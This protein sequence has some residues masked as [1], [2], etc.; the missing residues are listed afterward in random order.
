MAI[1]TPYQNTPEA[2]E[3]RKPDPIEVGRDTSMVGA[4]LQAGAQVL[5]A[6]LKVTDQI[7]KDRIDQRLF[8]DINLKRQEDTI[9]QAS[10]L[11]PATP[12]TTPDATVDIGTTNDQTLPHQVQEA[13][14][15]MSI[16]AQANKMGR[17]NDIQ[18]YGEMQEINQRIASQY[19]GYARYIQDRSAHWLGTNSANAQR[20][21]IQ[22]TLAQL[23]ATQ[24]GDAEKWSN[25]M[26]RDRKFFLK[27]D[28]T[29]DERAFAGAL[30]ATDP[31]VR[32]GIRVSIARQAAT[33]HSMDL[34]KK[35]MELESTSNT[36]S[37]QRAQQHYTQL[38]ELETARYTERAQFNF[39]GRSMKIKDINEFVARVRA[40]GG[41]VKP[42]VL[43]QLGAVAAQFEEGLDKA[44]QKVELD[45]I[46][47][48]GRNIAGTVKDKASL[49]KIRDF[50][51][52]NVF[53]SIKRNI[54]A[55][56]MA[57]ATSMLNTTAGRQE[58]AGFKLLENEVLGS[59]AGL[60]K[61]VG[62]QAAAAIVNHQ[63]TKMGGLGL[64]AL[65][66]TTKRLRMQQIASSS[67]FGSLNT[68]LEHFNMLNPAPG[69]VLT[70]EQQRER[71]TYLKSEIDTIKD[72]IVQKDAPAQSPELAV[73]AAR[74]ITQAGSTEFIT[75]FDKNQ[76]M[77]VYANI[78]APEVQKKIKELSQ[79]DPQLWK[80]YT[81]WN[82]YTFKRLYNTQIASLQQG[83]QDTAG[84]NLRWG[85][86]GQIT[87]QNP[88]GLQGQANAGVLSP[89]ATT[90]QAINNLNTGLATLRGVA[91]LNGEKLTPEFLKQFGI[92]L[93]LPPNPSMG[94]PNKNK[95]TSEAPNG[96]EGLPRVS[97]S[98]IGS[99]QAAEGRPVRTES[100]GG[101][102]N[103][104]LP[105]QFDSTFDQLI[106][107]GTNEPL[108]E[109]GQRRLQQRR[110]GEKPYRPLGQQTPPMWLR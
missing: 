38:A 70:P 107:Q 25:E 90:I 96:S 59:W 47:S 50:Y 87:F 43:A 109:E 16:I 29:F 103:L 26:E 68:A 73:R 92:T 82:Y 105:N 10:L 80:D 45:P 60:E 27:P 84:T 95:R 108:I 51:K 37:D 56:N 58:L 13:D 19:P 67:N 83:V 69:G 46:Y 12:Q 79:N 89:S 65:S 88:R 66:E 76:Q 34:K 98:L 28:G 91:E 52:E 97:F 62:G 77:Q 39:A 102:G 74:V 36:I 5:D 57:L 35:E 17:Y 100:V 86:N 7:N 2:K 42:E 64:D 3:Y 101:G 15:R 32:N 78:N 30:A 4:G 93:E 40:T 18:Y 106:D 63:I 1:F 9:A 54:G 21:A 20:T 53:G 44:L 23:S 72:F 24:K 49:T 85:E 81:E 71:A 94:T 14:R 6:S 31:N 61:A 55:G 48:G 75:K 11:N 33:E 104:N 22:T 99:A 110:S 8:E 41:E